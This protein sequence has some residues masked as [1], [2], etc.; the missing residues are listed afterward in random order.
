MKLTHARAG[1]VLA[2]HGV[3]SAVVP[4][5]EVLNVFTA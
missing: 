4:T 3:G 2:R 1:D 5:V